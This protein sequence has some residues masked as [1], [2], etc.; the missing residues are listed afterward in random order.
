MP[1]RAY[2]VWDMDP[3]LADRPRLLKVPEVAER[4]RYSRPTVY[5]KLAAGEIPGGVRVPGWR[6]EEARFESWLEERAA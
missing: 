1:F 5:R 4:L 2:T 3:T 6:V